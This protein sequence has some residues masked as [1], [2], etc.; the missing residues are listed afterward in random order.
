LILAASAPELRPEAVVPEEERDD[1]SVAEDEVEAW[2]VIAVVDA[3]F[4]DL[5]G[6]SVV[7]ACC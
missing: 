1:V 3:R 5:G 6:V 7:Q 4:H 2:A